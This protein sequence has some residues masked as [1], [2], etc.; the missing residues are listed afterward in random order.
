MP[1][2][3]KLMARGSAKLLILSALTSRPMHGYEVA[4]EIS[5]SF[6]GAYEPSPGVVY[7]TLQWLEDAGY[8]TG[9]KAD[10]KTVYRIT[11]GGESY[12]KENA[13]KLGKVVEFLRGRLAG[14]GDYPILRSATRLERTIRISL[15][16]LSRERREKVARILDEA[17]ERVTTLVNET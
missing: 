14:S 6:D 9:T 4:K 10:G 12:L 2:L 13:E 16:E 1:S 8:V 7:P 17:S 5:K 15:P 3:R 11:D